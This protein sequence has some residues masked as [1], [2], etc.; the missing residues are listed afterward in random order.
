MC[1]SGSGSEAAY[2]TSAM[3]TSGGA[4]AGALA[5]LRSARI[6]LAMGI[7]K[8]WKKSCTGEKCCIFFFAKKEC[9]A[10]QEVIMNMQ[11]PLLSASGREGSSSTRRVAVSLAV[12]CALVLA[13]MCFL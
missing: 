13:G 2:P 5:I 3:M 7:E 11:Q 10:T 4:E 12:G 8:I 6:G 9:E 1:T